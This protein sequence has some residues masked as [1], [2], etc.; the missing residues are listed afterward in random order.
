MSYL[1]VLNHIERIINQCG[2]NIS[3]IPNGNQILNENA[4]MSIKI[5]PIEILRQNKY[6][7]IPPPTPICNDNPNDKYWI[8]MVRIPINLADDYSKNF[9]LSDEEMKKF[10]SGKINL[11]ACY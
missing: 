5:N 11:F 1:A 2:D 7:V 9:P 4:E 8:N 3:I 6:F 10:I